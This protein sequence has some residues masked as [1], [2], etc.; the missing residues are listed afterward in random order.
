[1]PEKWR[2]G[3]AICP[4]AKTNEFLQYIAAYPEAV[5]V[6]LEIEDFCK[7]ERPKNAPYRDH[8]WFS[9][10]MKIGMQYEFD[11]IRGEK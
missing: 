9:D 11:F 8:Q 1:M 4:N 10:R 7:K 6:L 2:D 3:C 5:P